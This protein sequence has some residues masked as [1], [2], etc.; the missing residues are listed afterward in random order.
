MEER[1][2]GIDDVLK[3]LNTNWMVVALLAALVVQ[4]MFIVPTVQ[5][6]SKNV[7]AIAKCLIQAG[8]LS[9]SD[10]ELA[11]VFEFNVINL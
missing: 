10:V 5:K 9:P 4:S 11:Q 8:V 1:E 2:A 6:T 7:E 3:W